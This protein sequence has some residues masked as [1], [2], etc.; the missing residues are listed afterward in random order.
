MH[1]LGAILAFVIA[2]ISLRLFDSI[3][4]Y[5]LYQAGGGV[6]LNSLADPTT[7]FGVFLSPG[8]LAISAMATMLF[9][10]MVFCPEKFLEA[11]N[12]SRHSTIKTIVG[13]PFLLASWIA[14]AVLNNVFFLFAGRPLI[15][16][17]LNDFIVEYP[18]VGLIGFVA[19]LDMIGGRFFRRSMLSILHRVSVR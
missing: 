15:P 8:P 14:F 17:A 12:D 5:E 1:K 3:S 19:L 16:K 4:S 7:V 2:L 11:G 13:A 6:E 18:L 9:G 10:W